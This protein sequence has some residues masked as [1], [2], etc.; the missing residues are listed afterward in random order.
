M[1]TTNRRNDPAL[2]ATPRRAVLA[3]ALA[4]TFAGASFSTAAS[5]QADGVATQEMAD[6][7]RQAVMTGVPTDANPSGIT[8]VVEDGR[9]VIRGLV[10]GAD[11]R[12]DARNALADIEGLD[13]SLIDNRIVVQ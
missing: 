7:I 6:K 10:D 5:A 9:Y 3:A 4:A 2:L 8:V 12:Q 13:M 1:R 11:S